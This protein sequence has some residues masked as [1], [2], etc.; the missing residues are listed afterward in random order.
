MTYERYFLRENPFIADSP[1]FTIVDRLKVMSDV[2]GLVSDYFEAEAPGIIALLGDYGIG[3]TFTLLNIE[4][5]LRKGTFLKNGG[6]QVYP[7][8]MKA[9][10]QDS[11]AKYVL[12]VYQSIVAALGIETFISLLEEARTLSEEADLGIARVLKGVSPALTNALIR[13]D[14]GHR[15]EAWA[16]LSGESVPSSTLKRLKLA[17]RIDNNARALSMLLEILK[18]LSMIGKKGILLMIDEWEYVFTATGGKRGIQLHTAFKE[19]YDRVQEAK[20]R[21]AKLAALVF[22]FACTPKAWEEN[23]PNLIGSV[24]SGGIEPFW[25]R[26]ART[27]P[28]PPFDP[29]DT[30]D[31]IEKRLSARRTKPTKERLLPF[32]EDAVIK[33]HESSQ[34]V[35]R[36]IL[37][38]CAFLLEE[39]VIQEK[40]S[41]DGAFVAKEL[42]SYALT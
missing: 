36:R 35:P 26:I 30:R 16:Y 31:M 24:G 12:Y 20:F 22:L 2:S 19:I 29:H 34:G 23:I 17:S 33:I 18:L 10:P 8:Y 38:R 1:D 13:L 3:K 42:S 4:E 7:A 27:Y 40:D 25:Q 39:A 41:I 6:A 9:L 11:I 28:I 21:G 32:T 15:D 37:K 5:R 14:S